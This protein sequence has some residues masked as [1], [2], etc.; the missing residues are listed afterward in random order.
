MSST[1]TRLLHTNPDTG[2]RAD[3]L[4]SRILRKRSEVSGYFFFAAAASSAVTQSSSTWL[5]QSSSF[6]LQTSIVGV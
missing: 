4:A 3:R 2:P 1:P 5:S 6:L